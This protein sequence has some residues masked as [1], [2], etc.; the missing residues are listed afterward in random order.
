MEGAAQFLGHTKAQCSDA[1]PRQPSSPLARRVT[2]CHHGPMAKWTKR[3][4]GAGVIAGA[5][6][7]ACG[8]SSTS[9][10][11]RAG[12]SGR[13]SRSLAARARPRTRARRRPTGSPARPTEPTELR[14]QRRSRRGS[15]PTTALPRLAPGEGQARERDL[16]RPRRPDVRPHR[17]RPLLRRPGRR[18][19]RRPPGIEA[20][21]DLATARPTIAFRRATSRSS[22][23]PAAIPPRSADAS[24]RRASAGR[25]CRHGG[26]ATRSVPT[27]RGGTTMA[28]IIGQFC[29]NV[30]DIERSIA[31]WDGVMGVPLQSRTEIPGVHEAVH[32][33]PEGGSRIQLAQWTRPRGPDRHGHRDVEDLRQHPR[34]PGAVRPGRRRRLRIG[35]SRPAST[36]GRSPS[37]SSKTSTATCSS[38]SSTTKGCRR[39]CPIPRHRRDRPDREGPRRQGRGHH[40]GAGGIGR[41]MGERVR[42]RGHEARPLRHVT[43][44]RSTPTVDELRGRGIDVIGVVTDVSKLES[45]EA[46]RDA[47]I[48][49]FGAVHVV[50]NNAGVGVGRARPAV[51]ARDQRLALRVQRARLRRD[52]RH[53]RVRALD[54][55]ARRR[56]R[57]SSTRRRTTAASRPSHRRPRTPRARAPS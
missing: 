29:F 43:S 42:A 23:R 35:P 47:T 38:S 40:G 45:V 31:F 50:C 2:R 16:P 13:L 15:S 49:H 1:A 46:L 39:A 25:G 51:G 32:Q 54:A 5:A 21:T 44:P 7:R 56:R 18:R 9:E 20:L 8:G 34:L 10:P 17:A 3:L 11:G 55:R 27:T 26:F 19:G 48:D 14:G 24:R 4:L 30:T 28:Q 37:R 33:A 41:A 57:T 12:S 53:Q 22:H 36:A 52:Q 6:L